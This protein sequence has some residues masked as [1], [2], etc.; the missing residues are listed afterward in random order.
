MAPRKRWLGNGPIGGAAPIGQ[1]EGRIDCPRP[2]VLKLSQLEDWAI[3]VR[4]PQKVTRMVAPRI[5]APPVFAPIAPSDARK[6][7]EAIDTDRHAI[8]NPTEPDGARLDAKRGLLWMRIDRIS[9]RPEILFR[10][11]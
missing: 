1:D 2:P 11:G 6:I 7:S 4:A 3:I 10:L 8:V 9:S 5:F